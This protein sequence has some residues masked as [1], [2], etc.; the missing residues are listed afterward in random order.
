MITSV[1][2][3]FA[4]AQAGSTVMQVLKTVNYNH[5]CSESVTLDPS[6]I[7]THTVHIDSLDAGTGYFAVYS[8]PTGSVSLTFNPYKVA[9]N[10]GTPVDVSDLYVL[11][12]N[13]LP[14]SI[15]LSLPGGASAPVDIEYVLGGQ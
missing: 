6:G 12:F 7:S 2:S 10:G 3:Q 11:N 15:V 14:S 1:T 4:V 5:R 9:V 8:K 13:V